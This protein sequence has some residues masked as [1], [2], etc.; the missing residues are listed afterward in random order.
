MVKFELLNCDL[1]C[2]IST[3]TMSPLHCIP[4]KLNSFL[5]KFSRYHRHK[6]CYSLLCPKFCC[7]GNGEW[8]EKMAGSVQ[9]PVFE[10]PPFI[11]T[12][13]AQIF[14]THTECPKFCCRGNG[15][16][17]R[18]NINDTVKLSDSENHKYTVNH[19]S[20]TVLFL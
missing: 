9:W 14:S 20:G 18:I 7:N 10:P 1:C 15:G 5:H 17:L 11:D 12:K 19:K 6:P 16:R 13:I 4:Y 8:S 3:T 2:F